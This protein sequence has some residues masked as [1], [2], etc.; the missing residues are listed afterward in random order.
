MRQPFSLDN[1]ITVVGLAKSSSD[2]MAIP[3]L[4][5]ILAVTL[6]ILETTKVH[7]HCIISIH[8]DHLDWTIRIG[9]QKVKSN[10]IECRD[11]AARASQ[12][13]LSVNDMA[14]VQETEDGDDVLKKNL[15]NFLKFVFSLF[16]L[17]SA[18]NFRVR[19][20]QEI[21]TFMESQVGLGLRQRVLNRSNIEASINQHT[22]LLNDAWTT[23]HVSEKCSPIKFGHLRSS[24]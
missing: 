2:S 13:A 4:A 5:G 16:T 6:Y 17:S 11:M 9:I 3:G 14:K 8:V 7:T 19:V 12:V 15:D 22:S 10:R 21:A 20:L 24:L 18:N 1:A 23:F